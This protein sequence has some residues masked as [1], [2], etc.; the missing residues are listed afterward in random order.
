MNLGKREGK[1][2]QEDIILPAF[3]EST[4]TSEETGQLPSSKWHLIK[5]D[6]IIKRINIFVI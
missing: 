1:G 4:C 2:K 5:E 3:K 6:K